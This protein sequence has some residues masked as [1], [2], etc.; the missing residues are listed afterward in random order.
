MSVGACLIWV[1]ILFKMKDK[2]QVLVCIKLLLL[3]DV[4]SLLTMSNTTCL[5]TN[6]IYWYICVEGWEWELSNFKQSK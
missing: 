3:D 1:L 2:R 4:C 6:N 5:F